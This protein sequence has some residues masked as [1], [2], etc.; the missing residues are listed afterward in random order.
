LGKADAKAVWPPPTTDKGKKEY[1]LTVR[2]LVENKKMSILEFKPY[3]AIRDGH[4]VR[5]TY[6]LVDTLD[7]VQAVYG[8]KMNI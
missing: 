3:S 2:E 7:Q 8:N 5:D 6:R 1:R 4:N